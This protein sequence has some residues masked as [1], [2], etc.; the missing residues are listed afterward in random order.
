MAVHEVLIAGAG[1]QGVMLAG[2]LLAY[3][4]V[5]EDKNSSCLPAY[6]PE[7]R[8]G[9]ANCTVVISP[10]Q[11]ITPLCEEPK[12]IISL[13]EPSFHKFKNRVA[14]KGTMIINSSLIAVAKEETPYTLLPIPCNEIA[15]KLGSIHVANVVALGSYL[16]LTGA[17]STQA[18]LSAL[19][20]LLSGKKDLIPVNRKAL[21]EGAR[22][23]LTGR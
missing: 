3:G 6:G 15:K 8:G 16:Q 4:A 19:E 7:M 21:E 13:N 1:G 2:Q 11:I 12:T 5:K 23:V 18:L 20:E 17:I 22:Q 9:T 10:E 14:E